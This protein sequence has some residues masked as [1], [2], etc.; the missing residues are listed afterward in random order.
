MA[1]PVSLRCEHLEA[2]LGVNTTA[3][4]FSWK[5]NP[6]EVKSQTAYEIMAG[7]DSLA[8][9]RNGVADLW[10]SGKVVSPASVLVGYAGK[11]LPARTQGW[12]KVRVW[13]EKGRRGNGARH[14]VSVWALLLMQM[15][16][17]ADSTSPC[18]RMEEP[19]SM[20][21]FCANSSGSP[22]VKAR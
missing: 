10:Q 1:A 22:A 5:N 4:R 21:P 18:R 16:L 12:W 14:P 3:P 17:C 20:L 19:M 15:C 6:L 9:A 8:L 7:T 2:P 13:N 11:E